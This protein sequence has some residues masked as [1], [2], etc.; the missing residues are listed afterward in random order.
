[1]EDGRWKMEG[2]AHGLIE[3]GDVEFVLIKCGG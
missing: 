1:M 2:G 3:Q